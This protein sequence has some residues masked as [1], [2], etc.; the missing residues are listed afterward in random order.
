M[1]LLAKFEQIIVLEQ[2]DGIVRLDASLGLAHNALLV[3]IRKRQ[4]AGIGRGRRIVLTR[5]LFF[6]LLGDE[7]RFQLP[8]S[9]NE[10]VSH[11]APLIAPVLSQSL[12]VAVI[13]IDDDLPLAR[14]CLR[15]AQSFLRVEGVSERRF[16]AFWIEESWGVGEEVCHGG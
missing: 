6:P 16:G 4:R 2:L 12:R 10:A 7:L 3:Y 8:A 13:A 11:D 5:N 14:E 15:T 1:F 9:G